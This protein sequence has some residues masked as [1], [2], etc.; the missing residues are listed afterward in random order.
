MSETGK[1]LEVLSR[2]TTDVNVGMEEVVG[3]F[4]SQY[5]ETLYNRKDELQDEIKRLKKELS[6]LD[7]ALLEQYNQTRANYDMTN[8]VLGIKAEMT[9]VDLVW[10]RKEDYD[11]KG[12]KG[13]NSVVKITVTV[14]DL[15]KPRERYSSRGSFNKIFLIDIPE[16]DVSKKKSL[17]DE[18]SERTT[19]LQEVL[20]LI[21]SVSRKERQIKGRI[22][23]MKLDQAGYGELL[24]NA[25]LLQLIQL[26]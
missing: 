4:V 8:S 18:L 22:S 25:E 1:E 12:G 11:L 17:D 16:T 26:D 5:E 3:V 21:K 6:T 10:S 19:D 20:Q 7:K 23:K 2:L 14:S 13:S 24:E 15:D 9:G